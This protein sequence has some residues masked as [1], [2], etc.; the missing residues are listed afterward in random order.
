MASA[1]IDMPPG[2]RCCCGS[3][4][5][6]LLAHNARLLDGLERH[7][8]QAAQL[9]QALLVRHEEYV[10]DSERE[11]KH[12]MA[13]IERLEEEKLELEANNAQCI[14]ANRD[15]LDQLENLNEAVA[16]SDAHIE[17]LTD[18]LRSSEE[19]LDRLSL[20]AAR[21]QLLEKQLID[22]EREQSQ[23]QFNLDAKLVDERTAIQRWKTAEHTIVDLQDQTDRIEK[24]AKEERERHV[25]VVARMERKMAIE[26]ELNTAAGRLK[27][28]GVNDKGGTNVVSHFVKDI[29]L[30]NANLQHGISE[31]R[32]MLVSS[33]EEVERLRD[34]LKMHQP[35][36]SEEPLGLNLQKELGAEAEAALNQEVHIHHHYHSTKAS[37]NKQQAPRRPKKKRF[38]LTPTH[39]DPPPSRDRSSATTMLQQTSITIPATQRWSQASTLLAGSCPAS[40][41]TES[42]RGSVYDRVFSDVAYD[43]SRPTSPPDSI[44]LHSPMFGPT[45]DNDFIFDHDFMSRHQRR[46][47]SALKPPLLSAIRNTVT[48]TSMITKS[49][50]V[51]AIISAVS[52]TNSLSNDTLILSPPF[53]P[54]PQSMIPEENEDASLHSLTSPKKH[55]TMDD[56]LSPLRTSRPTLRRHISHESLISVS[57]MDIHTLQSRPS[58]LLYSPTPR[59][60]TPG[61]AG[62]AGPEL[63]PWTATAHGMLSKDAVNRSALTRSLSSMANQQRGTKKAVAPASSN[64]GIGKFV[65]GWVFGKWSGT[66]G[67]T[68]PIVEAS[69]PASISSQQAESVLSSTPSTTAA[70]QMKKKAAEKPKV[71]PSG[72]N[73]SGPIWGFFDVPE[74]PAKVVVQDYDAVALGEALAESS[75]H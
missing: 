28:K 51:T 43:S 31:L 36:S 9:G 74:A 46:R 24:E 17:A 7:V 62:S 40:P 67:T 3:A 39:F 60:T 27:A 23:L 33:N 16:D 68:T 52:P 58:Q 12:M 6:A 29:L 26:E 30:D 72:V 44:D 59:F 10:A 48:P 37:K 64:M 25:K 70:D 54:G 73:Q 13:T 1:H 22:L 14:K 71:R 41:V 8:S 5:C 69:R 63:T 11:R 2:L 21:T 38:S 19:E 49:T 53:E 18:T 42:H 45:K 56:I 32:E 61:G 55:E 50:P 4:D 35:I 34:Q 66:S 20:L 57:G 75:Q 15:L 65:G 47:S